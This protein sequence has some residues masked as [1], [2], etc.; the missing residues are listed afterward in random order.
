MN[1]TMPFR[2]IAITGARGLIGSALTQRLERAGHTVLGITRSPKS[3]TDIAWSPLEGTMDTGKLEGIDAA[4][5]LAGESIVGRWT[6]ARK[7]RIRD[8]RVQGTALIARTLAGLADKPRTLIVG[9]AIGYYGDRG[10]VV[11]DETATPGNNFLAKVCVEWEAAAAP[12]Q[13]AGIRVAH[14]RTGVVLTP[15][16]GA[17]AQMLPVFRLGLGGTIGSGSQWWS[18]ITLDD[19]ARALEHLIFNDAV[20]GPANLVAP[21]AGCVTAKQFTR[22]LG[23]ILRR[24]TLFP[25]PSFA[26]KIALGQFAEE[27]LLASQR[28]APAALEQS[29]FTFNHTALEPALR[30]VLN[31]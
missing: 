8:S 10:D 11:L 9:S 15:D 17:L 30:A 27:A 31:R 4:V 21:V 6:D 19:E 26:A 24:P 14:A 3:A 20:T 29:G 1:D 2:R 7:Q 13:D 5:H 12:A 16:G 28:V 22:A 25:V 23:D 18:W